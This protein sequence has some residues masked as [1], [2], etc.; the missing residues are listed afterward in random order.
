MIKFIKGFYCL[1]FNFN[2]DLHELLEITLSV[3]LFIWH[4]DFEKDHNSIRFT[5]GPIHIGIFIG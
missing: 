1:G 4:F 2:I 5:A 3:Y